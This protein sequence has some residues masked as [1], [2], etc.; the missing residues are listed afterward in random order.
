[1]YISV[2]RTACFMH[3]DNS[4]IQ[5]SKMRRRL[6]SKFITIVN[7]FYS[8]V[9][10]QPTYKFTVLQPKYTVQTHILTRSCSTQNASER[11]SQHY[12]KLYEEELK[13][14]LRYPKYKAMYD[15]YGLEIQYT[16]Y[17][18]GRVPKQLTAKNWLHLLRTPTRTE[19][20]LC[21]ISIL[22]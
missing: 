7:K 17:Q 1:M 20:R 6:P 8:T 11:I 2:V 13:C 3:S 16:K 21:L 10:I 19:R 15:R 18:T 12:K 5:F 14:L 22:I 9:F 4:V